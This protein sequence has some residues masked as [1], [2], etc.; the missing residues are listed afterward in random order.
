MKR[1]FRRKFNTGS[2]QNKRFVYV[3]LVLIFGVILI[4][5]LRTPVLSIFAPLWRGQ[6]SIALGFRNFSQ[7]IRSKDALVRENLDLHE[8]LSSY[9]ILKKTT[10]SL[11]NT[12]EELLSVF[13]R[14]FS[15]G[16]IAATVLVH[17][18]ETPYDILII[19]AGS[20]DSVKQGSKVFL[21][22]GGIIGFISEVEEN[23]SKVSL[24][25]GSGIETNAY[26]ERG[27]VSI[28]LIGAGG[29]SFKVSLPRDVAVEIGDRMLLP[30]IRNELVGVVVEVVLEPTDSTKRV[31]VRGLINVSNVRFVIVR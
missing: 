7:M 31:L 22:E 16:S 15:T 1:T 30:S 11:Q 2:T 13:G 25:S 27:D 5:L 20:S 26:L 4:S 9:E 6:N 28:R 18:P 19:D 29:G 24:Y 8:K 14:N 17:P 23:Q 10:S 12:E 3:F 21:P